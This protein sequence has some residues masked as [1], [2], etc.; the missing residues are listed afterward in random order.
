MPDTI[1]PGDP[2]APGALPGFQPYHLPGTSTPVPGSGQG[3]IE[4]DIPHTPG[5]APDVP[6]YNPMGSGN[7]IDP[8]YPTAPSGAANCPAFSVFDPLPS[9]NCFVKSTLVYLATNVVAFVFIIMG[10]YLIFRPEVQKVVSTAAN[11]TGTAAEITNPEITPAVQAARKI[12]A[13]RIERKAQRQRER[14]SSD[15]EE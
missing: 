14:D 11:V 4:G 2:N 5:I 9:V 7:R 8:L 3:T 10:A 13:S 15:N 12:R 6:A 1:P